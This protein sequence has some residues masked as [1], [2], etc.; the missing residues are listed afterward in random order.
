MLAKVKSTN[1]IVLK[2][3][4]KCVVNPAVEH[5]KQTLKMVSYGNEW[6]DFGGNYQQPMIGVAP[7]FAKASGTGNARQ[8][9]IVVSPNGRAIPFGNGSSSVIGGNS[10]ELTYKGYGLLSLIP[11]SVLYK[12]AY[13]GVNEPTFPY[14]ESG[15]FVSN[16]FV[17]EGF[18]GGPWD[19]NVGLERYTQQVLDLPDKYYPPTNEIW[20]IS[21]NSITPDRLPTGGSWTLRVAPYDVIKEPRNGPYLIPT[22]P[23]NFRTTFQWDDSLATCKAKLE[24]VFGSGNVSVT[25]S[26]LL[27]RLVMYRNNDNDK[28]KVPEN[29]DPVAQAEIDASYLAMGYNRTGV[30][31]NGT[32]FIEFTGAYAGVPMAIVVAEDDTMQPYLYG[33]QRV[34]I[35]QQTLGAGE[36]DTLGGRY[37]GDYIRNSDN[38][39]LLP[40]KT[41]ARWFYRPFDHLDTRVVSKFIA[42]LKQ[43]NDWHGWGYDLDFKVFDGLLNEVTVPFE[44]GIAHPYDN[45]QQ[46]RQNYS[47]NGYIVSMP[48]ILKQLRDFI[49]KVSIEQYKVT[50]ANNKIWA[51]SGGFWFGNSGSYPKHHAY[52]PTRGDWYMTPKN[53][54]DYL[55]K[56]KNSVDDFTS[57]LPNFNYGLTTIDPRTNTQ[58]YPFFAILK[59]ESR[60]V[61][62]PLYNDYNGE[63]QYGYYISKNIPAYLLFPGLDFTQP[64]EVWFER[65]FMWKVEWHDQISTMVGFTPTITNRSGTN[66]AIGGTQSSKIFSNVLTAGAL[67]SMMQEVLQDPTGFTIRYTNFNFATGRYDLDGEET[68]TISDDAV[69]I[70]TTEFTDESFAPDGGTKEIIYSEEL[71]PYSEYYGSGYMKPLW[72]G[73]F[74]N[75][76]KYISLAYS[77]NLQSRVQIVN[78]WF[79]NQWSDVAYRGN[80]GVYPTNS[81]L[82]GKVFLTPSVTI[83]VSNIPF[84]KVRKGMNT[85][86]YDEVMESFVA[87]GYSVGTLYANNISEDQFNN[88]QG[89]TGLTVTP[90]GILVP[91]ISAGFGYSSEWYSRTVGW[92]A[93]PYLVGNAHKSTLA[94][95]IDTKGKTIRQYLGLKILETTLKDIYVDTVRYM[96][97]PE[98]TYTPGFVDETNAN[99]T[100]NETTSS[101]TRYARG[102]STANRS[103]S[104]SIRIFYGKT[105]GNLRFPDMTSTVRP[106]SR[107]VWPYAGGYQ[108]SRIDGTVYQ[109]PRTIVQPNKE[110]DY[111]VSSYKRIMD[112]VSSGGSGGGGTLCVI[113]VNGSMFPNGRPINETPNRSNGI[114]SEVKID[115]AVLSGANALA[116]LQ[117]EEGEIIYIGIEIDATPTGPLD[118]DELKQHFGVTK[119][120][121]NPKF[122]YL[123]GFSASQYG[124]SLKDQDPQQHKFLFGGIQ[125]DVA[126]RIFQ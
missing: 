20:S 88:N 36:I 118:L 95:C 8:N 11:Q 19:G 70:G 66:Y 122:N 78:G 10:D 76:K 74:N 35:V 112:G 29:P 51:V 47:I 5:I 117:P 3:T 18:K 97:Y 90:S 38:S 86:T 55:K 21:F 100:V 116:D 113:P 98:E 107:D 102:G 32:M 105:P 6:D 87:E 52:G 64:R 37:V 49:A 60:G 103:F 34:K 54:D 41:I 62:K 89:N 17:S 63:R 106:D 61:A 85:I 14:H 58:R 68:W 72:D 99:W 101:V 84:T 94:Y 77:S 57:L 53:P 43:L 121:P 1:S 28:I 33:R 46:N 71:L 75:H 24:A 30:L 111:K 2:Q 27:E 4:V 16:V 120:G 40:V 59:S 73:I 119:E 56:G 31:C 96:L 44:D 109:G 79:G 23:T 125:L 50:I 9:L 93:E 126:N 26:D 104:G 80:Q 25:G 115:E 83:T 22:G 123:E 7:P 67:T 124:T 13:G 39:C 110:Y 91:R 15:R 81:T 114:V 69:T 108:I 82:Y 12:N 42:W 92:Q 48:K 65:Q 45:P